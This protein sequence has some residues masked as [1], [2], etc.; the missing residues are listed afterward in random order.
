[1]RL[2]NWLAR[3]GLVLAAGALL[4]TAI[5]VGVAPRLW[6]LANAHEELPVVLPGFQPLAQRSYVY[7]TERNEIAVFELENS[8]PVPLSTIPQHVIDAFLA[9]EDREFFRHDGI[10]VRSLVRA[11]LS[12]FASDAP[13]Q[14]AST[15]TMQVVKNDLLGGLERDGR[16]K[17]LQIHYARMLERE[18]TKEQILERYLNTVFMGNNA[19]GLQAAA[20]TYFAKTVGQLT[21]IE[22]A[23]LAGLV[24][25]PSGYDPINEPERSRRRFLQVLERLVQDEYLTGPEAEAIGIEFVLPERIQAIPERATTPTHYTEAVRDYLLNRTEILG[26]TYEERYAAL[27]RGGLRIYTTLNPFLQEHAERARDI[28]PDTPE[29]FD[30]AIT[31]VDTSTGAIRAMVGGRGFSPTNQINMALAPRQTGSSIKFFIL[32]AALQA[33]AEPLDIIDGTTP[34]TLP[35]TDNPDEPFVITDAENRPND[36]LEVMTYDSINCAYARLSQ[37]VGLNRVVDTTYR[38]A[39]SNYLFAG[40]SPDDRTPLMPYP[41]FAT[42]ANEMSPLDMASGAQSIANDGIHHEPYYIDRIETADGRQIYTHQSVGTRVLDR[43]VALTATSVLKKVLGPDG[44]AYRHPLAG[45]RPAAGKT[46]TQQNNTNSWFVGYTRFLATSVWIGDPDGYT[47]MNGIEEFEGANAD[48]VQ[49]G[50]YPAQIWKAFMDPAH[51]FEPTLDWSPPPQPA[52]K[53]M[54]LYL[55]GNECVRRIVDYTPGATIVVPADAA[56]AG[57]GGGRPETPDTEPPGTEPAPVTEPTPPPTQTTAPPVET[58]APTQPTTATTTATTAPPVIIEIPPEPIY[59][60]VASGTTIAPTNLN[61]RS[62]LPM[63][64][65][66][67]PIYLC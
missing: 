26:E 36:T 48:T 32:A 31:S 54:R 4:T 38:M 42:G 10:N 37:I 56:P 24:R 46:G 52:R 61:P 65:L 59:E 43:D 39:K 2:F 29:G 17:L 47:P 14:G 30:A 6:S 67:T 20:E 21:F 53:P 49:G 23:F 51:V 63:V 13:Q 16:Y 35:N 62:P 40:Q 34:C 5:V 55:P 25:S 3:L 18:Q 66:T 15:I 11:T 12:N 41:A 7:D 1:M 58:V 22:A 45:G 27:Y 8:Q 9:V 28:L 57:F 64:P 60:N 19:Y 33:G 50:R 44:T